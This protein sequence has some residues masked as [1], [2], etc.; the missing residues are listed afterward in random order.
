V[1]REA[2][3][4]LSDLE[5]LESFIVGSIEGDGVGRERGLGAGREDH[6]VGEDCAVGV[7][8]R[9][10]CLR[11]GRTAKFGREVGGE[12]VVAKGAV[13]RA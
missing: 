10:R 3:H 6:D 8:G 2:S 11:R 1:R 13:R 4:Q 9:C 7:E 5:T 12:E